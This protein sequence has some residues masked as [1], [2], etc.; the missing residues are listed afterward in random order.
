MAA[1]STPRKAELMAG[2]VRM[3]RR[4]TKPDKAAQI[5]GMIER[6]KARPVS[7]DIVPGTRC[8]RIE[9][10]YTGGDGNRWAEHVLTVPTN[11]PW[12]G[13]HSEWLVLPTGYSCGRPDCAAVL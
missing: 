8:V 12:S 10:T 2:L 5:A 13:Y 6:L 7:D 4:A 11:P 1:L 9:A 3:Q